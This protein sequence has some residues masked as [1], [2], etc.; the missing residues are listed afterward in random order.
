M[1]EETCDQCEFGFDVET[2]Y[3]SGIDTCVVST[4]TLCS[5]ESMY[6]DETQEVCYDCMANCEHCYDGESC[7]LCLDGFSLQVSDNGDLFCGE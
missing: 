7:D 2:D 5:H 3:D 4:E 1:D 6:I